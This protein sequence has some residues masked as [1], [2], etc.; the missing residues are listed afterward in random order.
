M[1]KMKTFFRYM[2]YY[3]I[4]NISFNIIFAIVKTLVIN[5]LGGQDI[6]EKNLLTSFRETFVIY[7]I[8]FVILCGVN[9]IYKNYIV[10]QLNQKLNVVKIR[11]EKYEK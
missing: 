1:K 7:T 5:R 3:V 8:L 4:G 9:M 6:L 10:Q 11:G 2:I